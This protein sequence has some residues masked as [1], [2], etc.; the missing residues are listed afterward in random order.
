MVLCLFYIGGYLTAIGPRAKD[1][2]RVAGD[3]TAITFVHVTIPLPIQ[4]AYSDCIYYSAIFLYAAIYC[5]GWNS[6]PLTLI[7]E[8]FNVRYRTTSMTL[9]LMWQ[10]L[11]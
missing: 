7:S 11:W 4:Y 2:P 8:I 3:Y 10:W 9:C 5:F 1:A 6:V